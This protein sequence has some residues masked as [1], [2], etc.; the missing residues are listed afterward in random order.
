MV[1]GALLLIAGLAALRVAKDP[2]TANAGSGLA[3]LGVAIILI[4]LA[5]RLP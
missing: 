3:I 1:V 5:V 4:K 2:P